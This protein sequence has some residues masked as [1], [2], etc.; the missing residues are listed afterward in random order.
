MNSSSCHTDVKI[1]AHRRKET[2]S[3]GAGKKALSS[4]LALIHI[5]SSLV[6]MFKIWP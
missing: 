6:E 1:G 5:K 3:Y 2:N 4:I